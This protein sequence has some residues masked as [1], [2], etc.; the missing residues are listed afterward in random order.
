MHARRTCFTDV[1]VV[2]ICTLRLFP[3]YKR[4]S[5]LAEPDSNSLGEWIKK[6]C[7]SNKR[8][9]PSPEVL[10][11]LEQIMTMDPDERLTA[12]EVLDVRACGTAQHRASTLVNA[13]QHS[14]PWTCMLACLQVFSH[15]FWDFCHA[16]RLVQSEARSVCQKGARRALT[17]AHN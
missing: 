10:A 5:T 3:R 17:Q 6:T 1:C 9:E 2:V 4:D 7:A 13:N 12:S 8:A 14:R 11:L 16:G 15:V